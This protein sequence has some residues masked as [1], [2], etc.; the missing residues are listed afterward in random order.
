MLHVLRRGIDDD[1]PSPTIVLLPM[2]APG[3]FSSMLEAGK[4][5]L[6]CSAGGSAA[7]SLTVLVMPPPMAASSSP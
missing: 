3:H 7:S 6:L 2:W 5:L 1:M 4:R